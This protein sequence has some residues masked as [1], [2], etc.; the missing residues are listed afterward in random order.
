M[1]EPEREGDLKKQQ[2]KSVQMTSLS[3][4]CDISKAGLQPF[5]HLLPDWDVPSLRRTG[6]SFSLPFQDRMSE[7]GYTHVHTKA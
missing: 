7:K 5:P 6:S 4:T 2:S 3:Q 1:R